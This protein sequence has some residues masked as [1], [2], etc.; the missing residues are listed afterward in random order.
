ML[1]TELFDFLDPCSPCFGIGT[2]RRR[3]TN[4]SQ[5]TDS[6]SAPCGKS[7]PN[8]PTN[9]CPYQMNSLYT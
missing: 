1:N 2:Y 4:H 9:F 7:A 5:R 3:R 6:I 8:D